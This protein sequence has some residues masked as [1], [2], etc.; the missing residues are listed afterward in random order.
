AY[1]YQ[2]RYGGNSMETN[3]I[4]WHS[5]EGTSL[6]S[7]GGGGSAPNLTAQPDF[8]NKRMVWYQHFDFDTSARALVNRAGGV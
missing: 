8:K 7:S 2:S 1:W 6:P 4:V 5:T 3:V